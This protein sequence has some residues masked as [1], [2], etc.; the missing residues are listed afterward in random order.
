MCGCVCDGFGIV[1]EIDD[2]EVEVEE[3]C[4]DDDLAY[5]WLEAVDKWEGFPEPCTLFGP[6]LIF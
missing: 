5:P 3:D 2:S 1:D 4:L 6:L